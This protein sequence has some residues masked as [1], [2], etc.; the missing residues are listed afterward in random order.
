MTSR[1]GLNPDQKVVCSALAGIFDKIAK[2]QEGEAV[3]PEEAET[4]FAAIDQPVAQCLDYM[5]GIEFGLT[6]AELS[7][8]LNNAFDAWAYGK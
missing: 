2:R 5:V 8:S 6:G 1:Q 4:L 3:S 7:T